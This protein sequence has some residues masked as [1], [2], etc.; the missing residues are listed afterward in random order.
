MTMQDNPVKL[1]KGIGATL[2]VYSDRIVIKR[3]LLAKL[4]EGF[5][6]DK[7][8]PLSKITSIQFQKATFLI[9]GY[10]QF[11]ISGGNESTGGLIDASKDE[12][13]VL[14]ASDKNEVA[15]KVKTYLE[16]RT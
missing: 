16:S 12:N 2:E 14:F 9:S 8:I 15:E 11:S 13:S 1:L 4:I 5:R 10:I 3:K 6:G 7:S